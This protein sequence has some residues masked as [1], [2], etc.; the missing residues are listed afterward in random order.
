MTGTDKGRPL[1]EV[2]RDA[3]ERMEQLL[4]DYDKVANFVGGCSDG[5]CYVTGKANG[6][7]TNGGCSCYEDKI[8]RQLMM[9]AG[10]VLRDKVE[11]ILRGN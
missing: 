2:M 1:D 3:D 4:A 7:H 8:T 11:E 6:M 9:R 5:W 10:R